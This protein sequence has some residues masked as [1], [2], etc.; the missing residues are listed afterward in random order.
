MEQ[1]YVVE[2]EPIALRTLAK[3]AGWSFRHVADLCRER[4]WVDKRK[5]AMAQIV[6]IASAKA[7]QSKGTE[8]AE[9]QGIAS[10]TALQLL[11]KIRKSVDASGAAP[12][13]RALASALKDALSA[14][15]LAMGAPTEITRTIDDELAALEAE[16][17]E[18]P[19]ESL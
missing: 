6:A 14:G 8:L 5:S 17:E 16:L 11:R 13:L 2:E 3:L 15:H 18:G 7:I 19:G 9:F 1:R 10:D 4:G 12:V